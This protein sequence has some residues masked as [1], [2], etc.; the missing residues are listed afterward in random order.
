MCC[1]RV[2]ISDKLDVTYIIEGAQYQKAQNYFDISTVI[3]GVI[4]TPVMYFLMIEK[5]NPDRCAA[6]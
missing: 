3:F 5:I 4:F 1:Y 2:Q 6:Y